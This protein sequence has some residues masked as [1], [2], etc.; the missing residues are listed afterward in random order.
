VAFLLLV[1]PILLLIPLLVLALG[2]VVEQVEKLLPLSAWEIDFFTRMASGTLP[3]VVATCV[4]APVLDRATM[5]VGHR[6][7]G[8]A[9]VEQADTTTLVEAGWN[10]EVDA[11]MNLVLTR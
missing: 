6:F 5:P 10:A 3:A 1:L 4:L 11:A 7:A 8:P 9:L 2:F